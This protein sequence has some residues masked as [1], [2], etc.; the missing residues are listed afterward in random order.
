VIPATTTPPKLAKAWGLKAETILRWIRS[1]ELV[2]FNVSAPGRRPRW[3]ITEQAI[4][5]FIAKR[6]AK[7]PTPKAGR[8]KKR[9]PNFVEYF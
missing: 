3:K 1:G 9:D 5:D 6:S 4:E 8:R 7:P 2:A